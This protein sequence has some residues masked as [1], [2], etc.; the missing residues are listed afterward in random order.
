ML[1][2]GYTY[3]FDDP[4]LHRFKQLMDDLLMAMSSVGMLAIEQAPWIRHLDSIINFGYRKT[5][6]LNDEIME[7]C[8]VEV[9]KHR[10]T[11]KYNQPPRDYT[12]AYLME[13]ERRKNDRDMGS[14]FVFLPK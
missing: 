6:R 8:R 10:S 11:I 9:E 1:I 3:E 2:F 7:F 12:D 5:K 14:F 4:K 13:I